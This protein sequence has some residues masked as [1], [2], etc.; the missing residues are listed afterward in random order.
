LIV[1][2]SGGIY[3]LY[4]ADDENHPAVR[5]VFLHE[6]DT[7]HVPVACLAEIDY[8]LRTRLGL[9][10]ELDFLEAVAVGRFLLEPLER[11]DVERCVELLEKYR[12]LDIGL[13]D[14]SV[15]AT[16]ERLGTRRIL[17][18]DVRDFEVIRAVDGT[19]FSILPMPRRRRR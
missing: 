17:T 13:S 8:L 11:S 1:A 9:Q 7:V 2:D 14:A 5:D 3:A 12:K 16:A 4:D 15:V 6:R 19:P 18:V 10:A